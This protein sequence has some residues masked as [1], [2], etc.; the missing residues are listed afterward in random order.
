MP[1]PS[2]DAEFVTSAPN[3][4]YRL[5][6]YIPNL[7]GTFEMFLPEGGYRFTVRELPAGYQVKTLLQSGRDLL[8]QP[9]DLSP[10]SRELVVLIGTRAPF[11]KVIGRVI[12]A[13][14]AGSTSS[15]S[16]TLRTGITEFETTVGPEGRFEFLKVPL[17]T[18]TVSVDK[19]GGSMSPVQVAIGDA[20]PGEPRITVA[21]KDV[22]DLRI[23]DNAPVQ[24]FVGTGRVI[25]E[26][27]GP[28][29]RFGLTFNGG[30]GSVDPSPVD[31]T[32]Q[33]WMP[34]GSSRVRI[35]DLPKEYVLKSISYGDTNLL[36]KDLVLGAADATVNKLRIVVA[37][38]GTSPWKRVAG[39]LTGFES[40]GTEPVRIRLSAL[41]QNI[42]AVL[43]SDGSFV[44]PKMLS[45]TYRASIRIGDSVS[46]TDTGLRAQV[47]IADENIP[48]LELI[49]PLRLTVNIV[50][51]AG[52]QAAD[53]LHLGVARRDTDGRWLDY[54]AVDG[55]VKSYFTTGERLEILRVPFGYRVKSFSYGSIDL[56]KEALRFNDGPADRISIVL[57]SVPPDPL[58]P[59]YTLKGQVKSASTIPSGTRATATYVQSV[60]ATVMY[61]MMETLV[62][63]DGSFQFDR[64][65]PGPYEMRI[66]GRPE[67]SRVIV[68]NDGPVGVTLSIP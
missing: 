65:P 22:E 27:D 46:D 24:A 60:N 59:E 19:P 26:G 1:R 12:D 29:P 17:G 48:V 62:R 21:D 57:E 14:N 2:I 10:G 39:R 33:A 8:N 50:T 15:V 64:L 63:D 53:L 25:V 45:G 36:E 9:F 35:S 52:T 47:V 55:S 66:A 13:P 32:F 68:P 40:L 44:F 23:I 37:P 4:R 61:T 42:E 51:D 30:G 16:A 34:V 7:D 20:P 28:M 41:S 58:K 56:L 49:A 43:A 11:R 31:G 18:Y 54:L 38:S 3:V 5:G 6:G 67:L